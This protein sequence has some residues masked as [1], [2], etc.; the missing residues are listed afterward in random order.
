MFPSGVFVPI[1]ELQ[2]PRCTARPSLR[3]QPLSQGRRRNLPGNCP[4]RPALVRV[5]FVYPEAPPPRRPTAPS[6]PPGNAVMLTMHIHEALVEL[7]PC[8][9]PAFPLQARD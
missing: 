8:P 2:L 7:P 9:P 6:A 4:P 1:I 3:R 5:T